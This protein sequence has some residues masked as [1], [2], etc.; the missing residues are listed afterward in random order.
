MRELQTVL[1]YMAFQTLRQSYLV[2]SDI[3]SQSHLNL[4]STEFDLFV[5]CTRVWFFVLVYAAAAF[6]LQIGYGAGSCEHRYIGMV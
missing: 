5:P 6:E 4:K 2:R 1:Q 3:D